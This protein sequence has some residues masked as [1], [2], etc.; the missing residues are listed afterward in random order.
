ME[1]KDTGW[2]Q[3]QISRVGDQ[4]RTFLLPVPDEDESETRIRLVIFQ[5][6]EAIPERRFRGHASMGGREVFRVYTPTMEEAK[7]Q[8]EE[9]LRG[10]ASALLETLK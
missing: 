2:V 4:E 6:E 9:G 3:A 1:T 8:I 10:L 5:C 7:K